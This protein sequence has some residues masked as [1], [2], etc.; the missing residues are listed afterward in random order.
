V[1]D[2]EDKKTNQVVT[3]KYFLEKIPPGKICHVSDLTKPGLK[4]L[5]EKVH[6]VI[7]EIQLF[8]ISK[9]CKG[10][11]FFSIFEGN[12]WL[13]FFKENLRFLIF[14]CNSCHKT[15]KIFAI[16]IANLKWTGEGSVYKFGELP[17]FCPAIPAKLHRLIQADRYIFLT[18]RRAENQ[19]MGIGALSYYQRV[20]ENQKDRIFDKIIRVTKKVSPNNPVIEALENAK[21]EI[22]FTLAVDK[23]KH[24]L[25]ESLLIYGHNP[26]TLLHSALS[27]GAHNFDDAECLELATSIRIIL[28]E[29]SEKLSLAL[30]DDEELKMAINRLMRRKK[31]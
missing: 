27:E 13:V 8:C 10:T 30:K 7:P 9:L 20:I 4:I 3:F 6:L 16:S 28:I 23:V 22:L 12:P 26:L 21:K 17:E 14:R 25:P 5:K 18:G 2:Q 31:N 1:A 29:L 11:R 24:E 15:V 19:N